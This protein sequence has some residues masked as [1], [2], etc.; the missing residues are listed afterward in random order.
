MSLLTLFCFNVEHYEH[1]H[2]IVMTM[3]IYGKNKIKSYILNNNP[4]TN[5]LLRK[6][7]NKHYKKC[8]WEVNK[9]FDI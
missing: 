2:F 1:K 6:N 9:S 7:D 8:G 3:T 5:N 4:L